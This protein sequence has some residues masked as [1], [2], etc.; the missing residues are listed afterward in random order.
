MKVDFLT[1][2]RPEKRSVQS[3]PPTL[4]GVFTGP[5]NAYKLQ[6]PQRFHLP[7]ADNAVQFWM[8]I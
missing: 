4:S 6:G 3:T 5:I 1:N 2:T 7:E 8:G